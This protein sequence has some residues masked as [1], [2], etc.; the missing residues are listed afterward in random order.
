MSLIRLILEDLEQ[1]RRY[2]SD[3]VDHVSDDMWFRQPAVGI[4]HI[5]WQVGHITIAEYGLCLKRVRGV[6][7]GDHEL[8]PIEDYAR[9]FGK[10]SL[11]SS[12]PAD[13]PAP[14]E[15]LAA[16]AAIHDKVM[17]ETSQLDPAVLEES[18]GVTH[19]MY[20]TKGDALRFSPKHELLHVGQI[21]LLR[22][23]F[24]AEILR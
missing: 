8:C 7:P 20:S 16:F 14:S 21:G 22:R 19:P 3:M 5:A 1:A 23:L 9:L 17:E 12:N 6:L 24:G 11:P 10:G 18:A 4:N 13:Y 2:T 15:I